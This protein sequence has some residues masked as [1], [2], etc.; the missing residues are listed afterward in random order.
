MTK[1]P[2]P[3][4]A[5]QAPLDG[6]FV[7]AEN[8]VRFFSKNGDPELMRWARIMFEKIRKDDGAVE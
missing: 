8:A 6:S 5:D 2:P 1:R 3:H 7:D 4:I